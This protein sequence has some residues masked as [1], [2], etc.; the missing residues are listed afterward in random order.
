[1]RYLTQN[2]GMFLFPGGDH[3]T[4]KDFITVVPLGINTI[5]EKESWRS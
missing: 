4:Q 1:M 3:D 2:N 5:F